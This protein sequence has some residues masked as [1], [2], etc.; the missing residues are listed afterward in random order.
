MNAFNDL[1]VFKFAAD[2]GYFMD[3]DRLREV[4]H[5]NFKENMRKLIPMLIPIFNMIN[6]GKNIMLL[7]LIMPNTISAFKEHE[8]LIK[9]DD[10]DIYRYCNKPS[11]VNALKLNYEHYKESKLEYENVFEK[12]TEALDNDLQPGEFQ[13][14]L[15]DIGTNIIYC[16]E[17]D[18]IKI[19]RIVGNEITEDVAKNIVAQTHQI[20]HSN[21][22]NVTEQKESLKQMKQDLLNSA[23]EQVETQAKVKSLGDAKKF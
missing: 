10:F 2:Y 16:M 18:E 15:P 22:K 8:L 9:M 23:S 20:V 4:Q 5:G 13:I 19:V 12:V 6:V 14:I 21:E 1:R 17:K 7:H 3:I 11:L